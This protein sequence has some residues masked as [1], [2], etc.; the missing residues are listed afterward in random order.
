MLV[1]VERAKVRICAGLIESVLV[2]PVRGQRVGFERT[3]IG[4]D[5]MAATFVDPFDCRTSRDGNFFR[6]ELKV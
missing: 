1:A 3:V 5:R 6:R 4:F 2:F